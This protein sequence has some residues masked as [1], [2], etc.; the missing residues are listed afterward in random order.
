[1][2]KNG[3]VLYQLYTNAEL[4]L[5]NSGDKC[6]GVFT[7]INNKICFEKSVLDYAFVHQVC[8]VTLSH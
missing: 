6:K 4:E 8:L 7:R 5:L 3:K 2:S 1:M